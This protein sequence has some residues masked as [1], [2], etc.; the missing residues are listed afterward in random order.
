ME[1]HEGKRISKSIVERIIE[2]Y[3]E[4]ENVIRIGDKYTKNLWTKEGVRQ[5]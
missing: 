3:E 4:T 1:E 5:G 2:L